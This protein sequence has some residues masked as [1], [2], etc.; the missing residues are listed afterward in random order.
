MQSQ[1]YATPDCPLRLLQGQ[2][3]DHFTRGSI[4]VVVL[5]LLSQVFNSTQSEPVA[6]GHA[7]WSCRDPCIPHVLFKS[8][9]SV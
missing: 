3:L 2:L 6:H 7:N 9:Q 1:M 4:T 5:Q 8:G